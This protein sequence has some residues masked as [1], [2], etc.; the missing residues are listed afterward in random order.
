MVLKVAVFT[1]SG[2]D[3][4]CVLPLATQ[5][6][7][8]LGCRVFRNSDVLNRHAFDLLEVSFRVHLLGWSTRSPIFDWNGKSGV[9]EAAI[10]RLGKLGLLVSQGGLRSRNGRLLLLP[11]LSLRKRLVVLLSYH[12][13]GMLFCLSDFL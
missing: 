7:F 10:E 9:L 2:G 6:L 11:E 5:A 3:A 4:A 1:T 12:H 13:L 8:G